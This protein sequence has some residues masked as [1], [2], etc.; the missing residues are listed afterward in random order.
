VE[1]ETQNPAFANGASEIPEFTAAGVAGVG[2]AANGPAYIADFVAAGT[3]TSAIDAN[4][5]AYIG[6]FEH[7]IRY[8][9]PGEGG[10][11]IAIRIGIGLGI[12][13]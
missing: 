11:R 9:F 10:S 3:A 4:G 1:G 7:P 5:I 12:A 2:V 6:E 8:G 13:I